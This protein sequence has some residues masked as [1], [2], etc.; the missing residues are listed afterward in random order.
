[1]LPD[2][3]QPYLL[4]NPV[5]NTVNYTTSGTTDLLTKGQLGIFTCP[6]Q[7][8]V[9]GTA[10]SAAT[11]TPCIIASGSWHLIDQITPLWGG[12]Q[13]PDYTKIIDWSR[14]TAFIYTQAQ[15][16]QNQ[17]SVFGWNLTSGS[18][19]GPAFQCG[20][21]YQFQLE[22][23]GAPALQFLNHQYYKS[24]TAF[25]GCCGTGCTSGCTT[26]NVDAA[27]VMLQWKDGITQDPYE[28]SFIYPQVFIQTSAGTAVEVFSAY[29]VIRATAGT[30]GTPPPG[31]PG[32]AALQTAV[33]NAGAY[34][35]NTSNPISVVAGLQITVAYVQ[36]TFGTCTFSP[37]DLYTIEPLYVEGSLFSQTADPCVINTTI[38]TSVP[39]MWTQIT[40]PLQVRGIGQQVARNLIEWNRYKQEDFPD[41]Q[42]VGSLR[43]RTIEDDWV[44]P[45]V[46]LQGLYD[47]LY[48]KF[49]VFRPYNS[50]SV[51]DNDE[52]AIT[53]YFPTGTV[54]TPFTTLINSC[55]TLSANFIQLQTI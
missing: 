37:T 27:S 12:L 36:T 31:T 51:T 25:S 40:A 38:D 14:V 32:N 6:P 43:M 47:S 13:E 28:T 16:P 24:F 41:N 5:S 39:T 1:M 19:V 29:D 35:P 30:Y 53:I 22:L 7:T 48:L 34:V 23:L 21:T 10:I 26:S 20:T 50:Q 15:A 3:F 49:N 52:Y 42:W 17:V 55:L 33:L 11:L 2:S 54:I 44:M 45:N 9:Y 18:T 4:N 46:A 8:G